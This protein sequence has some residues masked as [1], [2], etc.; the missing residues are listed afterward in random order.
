VAA[1]ID[2]SPYG[3]GVIS[4]PDVLNLIIRDNIVANYGISPGAEVCGIYVYHGEGIE[5]DSNQ[6]RESRDL[7]GSGKVKWSN[8]GGKRAGI[9]IDLATPPVLDT[10]SGSVWT[11]SVKTVYAADM[12]DEYRYRPPDY[13]PGYSALRIENNTVRV[14]FGLALN[15]RGTGPFSIQGNHF[16]TGGTIATDSAALRELEAKLPSLADVGTM[17][18]ALTISIMNLGLSLEA[19][20]PLDSFESPS[21]DD[22]LTNESNNSLS[23]TNG[24]VLFSNNICQLMA[25]LN[26]AR[27][28]SS[29]SIITRDHL[30]F[31]N[32]EL[33]INGPPRTAKVD[34]YLLG[35]SAQAVA[36]RLQESTDAVTYSGYSI[37]KMNVTSQNISTYCFKSRASKAEWW[38][39][40]PNVAFHLAKCERG[41]LS[42]T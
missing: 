27:G 22:T 11:E 6:I 15:V 19:S 5:I 10:S 37:G 38:I 35:V 32:N 14:A 17:S 40:S 4:L 24:T 39:Q 16:S 9:Y 23:V 26:Y 25:Q 7:S 42:T 21:A 29:V 2:A 34:A 13:A 8:Y 18:G 1:A 3:Y 12:S 36:N 33:W 20:D 28:I 30:M 31:T 41:Y